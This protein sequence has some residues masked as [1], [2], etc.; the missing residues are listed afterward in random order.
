M[1]SGRKPCLGIVLAVLRHFCYFVELAQV[2]FIAKKNS[3]LLGCRLK[4]F[5]ENVFV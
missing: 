1:I 4:Y 2:L 3:L 5:I